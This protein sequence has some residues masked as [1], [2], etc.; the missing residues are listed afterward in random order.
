MEVLIL[1]KG[2]NIVKK[3]SDEAIREHILKNPS[4]ALEERA[5]FFSVKHQSV[6]AR[7]KVLDIIR[8]KDV[9]SAK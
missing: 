3:I 8:K 6:Y 9:N 5:L 1:E 2:Q 4:A 7:M